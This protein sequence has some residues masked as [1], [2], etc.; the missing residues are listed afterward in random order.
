MLLQSAIAFLAFGAVFSATPAL[1]FTFA[2]PPDAVDECL[3]QLGDT[4]SGGGISYQTFINR[5]RACFVD[6]GAGDLLPAN[7]REQAAV[8]DSGDCLVA[9]QKIYAASVQECLF[10]YAWSQGDS[11]AE[12]TEEQMRAEVDRCRGGEAEAAYQKSAAACNVLAAPKNSIWDTPVL[13]DTLAH[14]G[15]DYRTLSATSALALAACIEAVPFDEKNNTPD[16]EV[17]ERVGDCFNQVGLASLARV[18]TNTAVTI[19]CAEETSGIT[20]ARDLI[21]LDDRQQAYFEQCVT[22]RAVPVAVAASAAAVPLAAGAHNMFLFFQFLFTQP[23]MLFTRRKVARGQVLDSLTVAPLDLSAVRLFSLPSKKLIKTMVTGMSGQYLFVPP[24][25]NYE[26]EASKPGYVFP[27]ER[28][29]EDKTHYRGGPIAVQTKDD[30]VNHRVPLDPAV[31]STSVGRFVFTKWKRR[32]AATLA[33][34]A[35]I[36]SLAAFFLTP[37]WWTATL[38]LAQ[39]LLLLLFIRLSRRPRRRLF[40]VVKDSRGRGLSGVVVSLFDPKFNKLLYYYVTDLFGRYVL[41]EA[42]GTFILAFKK[43]GFAVEQ[44]NIT[45]TADNHA[46]PLGELVLSPE[47]SKK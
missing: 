21:H 6:N 27:S 31:L 1:A 28:L 14:L 25:G 42:Q 38:V 9:A 16:A 32:L 37:R 44:K 12:P 33:F 4:F 29:A 39:A 43:K 24:P 23:A 36:L 15:D 40:G 19:N 34:V 17:Q 3:V 8:S 11:D 46:A 7:L 18:Y 45:L 5:Y 2:E 13:Q 10:Q 41:P 20:G 22:E 47:I 26:L 30:V 35:P